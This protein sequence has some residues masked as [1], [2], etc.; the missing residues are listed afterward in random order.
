MAKKKK[1]SVS[2]SRPKLKPLRKSIRKPVRVRKPKPQSW[3]VSLP[4]REQVNAVRLLREQVRDLRQIFSGFD[5]KDGFDLRHPERWSEM[6]RTY[7][8]LHAKDLRKLWSRR[9]EQQVVKPRARNKALL[10]AQRAALR[11]HTGQGLPN[12]RAWIVSAAAARKLKVAYVPVPETPLAFGVK[13]PA[14]LRVEVRQSVKGGYRLSQD[15]LFRE[16]LGGYQPMNFASMAEATRA[17]LPLM[18][19]TVGGKEAYY[20]LLSDS[21][22][23]VI[24]TPAPKSLLIEKLLQWHEEYDTA[25]YVATHPDFA[26]TIIGWRLQGARLEAIEKD[27]QYRRQ[28]EVR[29][30]IRRRITSQRRNVDPSGY[31]QARKRQQKLERR[32]KLRSRKPRKSK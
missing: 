18:P 2:R 25:S 7:V 29:Q 23:G 17:L 28:R 19:D 16:L 13:V 6:A 8:D 20:V 30:E 10:E 5:S 31:L 14:R 1:R 22:A 21:P 32:R 9:D 24:S 3:F 12:Q 27:R 11:L 15:F 26:E 4:K